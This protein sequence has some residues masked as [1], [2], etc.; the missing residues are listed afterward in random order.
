[1]R[2]RYFFADAAGA[3]A[4]VDVDAVLDSLKVKL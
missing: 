4:A 3:D 1:V 2:R